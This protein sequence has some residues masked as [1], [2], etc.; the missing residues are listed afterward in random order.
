MEASSLLQRSILSKR[1]PLILIRR[2]TSY[3]EVCF[4]KVD[5]NNIKWHYMHTRCNADAKSRLPHWLVA[6]LWFFWK[7][8]WMNLLF[9]YF[10]LKNCP[11]ALDGFLDDRESILNYLFLSCHFITWNQKLQCSP[12]TFRLRF[13]GIQ[14]VPKKFELNWSNQ[15]SSRTQT[16]EIWIWNQNFPLGYLEDGF[17]K[18][19]N[20][21]W[22]TLDTI[23]A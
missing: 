9:C 17:V 11:L 4:T 23:K 8:F 12:E 2:M 1:T 3:I 21:F 22:D 16:S 10:L 6:L 13:Y 19:S 20:F 18:S 14:G 5:Q 15:K 7:I